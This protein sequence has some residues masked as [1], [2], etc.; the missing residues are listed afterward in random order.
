MSRPSQYRLSALPKTSALT[1]FKY[2]CFWKGVIHRQPTPVQAGLIIK[3]GGRLKTPDVDGQSIRL[4]LSLRCFS[5]A[6]SHSFQSN[7]P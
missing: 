4:I 2:S 6:P 3:V 7:S 1:T 5:S